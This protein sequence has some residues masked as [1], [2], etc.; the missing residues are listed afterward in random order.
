MAVSQF[1]PTEEVRQSLELQR[2]SLLVIETPIQV[3]SDKVH[4]ERDE[5]TETLLRHLL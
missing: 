4:H 3:T 1:E 5:V 2:E